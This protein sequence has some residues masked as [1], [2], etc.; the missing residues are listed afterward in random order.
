[1]VATA[2]APPAHRFGLSTAMA[3]VAGSA[4]GTTTTVVPIARGSPPHP[5]LLKLPVM[6]PGRYAAT[7]GGHGRESCTGG[8]DDRLERPGGVS[9]SATVTARR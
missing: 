4:I 1:M 7:T 5:L 3:L 6:A 8:H 2:D 9:C